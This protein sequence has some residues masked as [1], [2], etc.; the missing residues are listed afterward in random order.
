V[1]ATRHLVVVGGGIAGLAAAYELTR[2]DPSP[3]VTLFESSDRLGGKLLTSPFAGRMLDE[4]ADAF[5]VRVPWALELCRELGLEHDLVA[6][7][8]GTAYVWS[9]GEL[10]RL[11]EATVLGV[12]TDLDALAASGVV[13]DAGVARAAEDLE[14]PAD[15]LD[16]DET[17]GALVRRRLG[18]EV[19]ERIVGPLVGGINAGDADRLSLQAVTPQLAAAR[20]AGPSL[21]VALRA[22]RDAA[23]RSTPPDTPVFLSPRGGMGALA[24]RLADAVRQ[25]ATVRT[26]VAVSALAPGPGGEWRVTGGGFELTADA[27]LLTAPAPT[28]A[29]LLAKTCPAA[30]ST[31][32]A[33][34]HASVVLVSFAYPRAAIDHPLDGSGFL[35]P[36][37]EGL[38]MT[39]C[40]WATSKWA[41]LAEA[42][43]DVLLRVSAGRA[44]DAS[45]VTDAPDDDI[46]DR[47]R[48]DLHTT[49]GIEVAPSAVRVSRWPE[50]FPQ[51]APGHLDRIDALDAALAA[52]APGVVAAGAWSRGVGVPACI[53]AGR[54][55]AHRALP[56][57]G[58]EP[59]LVYNS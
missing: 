45:P 11:P 42:G 2:A 19:L 9:R 57:G 10:R 41:H 21:V 56:A 55:A 6:P 18:D 16:G 47:L 23:A 54:D 35:V 51:Y 44:G 39:A 33:L 7:A 5:L 15:A 32:R 22:Q 29:R 25:R 1:S 58:T 12:P 8:T 14:R 48:A 17:V 3:E 27:V 46:V 52:A 30:A 50:G 31:L 40:S 34:D 53:N 59:A 37:V 43:A 13:S 28:T 20:D 26:G 24:Y 36:A 4:G 49:M 38:F